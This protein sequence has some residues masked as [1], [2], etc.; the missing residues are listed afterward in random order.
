MTSRF[1]LG[2]IVGVL[3]AARGGRAESRPD[4]HPDRRCAL[5]YLRQPRGRR[6]RPSRDY[7]FESCDNEF[8]F[9]CCRACGLTYLRNRPALDTLGIIYPPSYYRYAA[10]LGPVTTRLRGIVQGARVRMIRRLLGAGAT[11]MEVGCGEGQLLQAIKGDGDP[12]W[13]VVGVDISPEAC[14]ALRRTRL[15]MH[16]AQFE[17]LEWPEGTVD[18]VIMNQVIEHLADP[19]ACVAKA[20]SLLRP[21]G[22]LMI[23]TPSVHS[24]DRD[25]VA[26]GPLG[27]LA[28]PATLVA[29]HGRVAD[30]SARTAGAACRGH[31]VPP[32]PVRAGRIRC[33]TWCATVRPGAG[34]PACCR[35]GRCLP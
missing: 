35:S 23:E 29:V 14:A 22:I 1:I 2:T 34:R 8:V 32:E 27:G 26:A 15:E 31:R 12:S 5:Q 25:W 9:V 19:R 18:L 3:G 33:R 11:V 28:L 21:G 24:W 30:P 6:G 17:A 20:A 10:F 7:E 13:R 4:A 16:C